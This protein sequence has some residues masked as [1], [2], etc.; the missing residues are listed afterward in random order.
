[1]SFSRQQSNQ[2]L[3]LD[4]VLTDTDCSDLIGFYQTVGPSHDYRST[5]VRP[6]RPGQGV[7]TYVAKIVRAFNEFSRFSIGISWCEIVEWPKNASHA[8]HVDKTDPVA[9]FT[10]ITYL[11]SDYTGG[12]TY[13]KN[14][15]SITPKTGRTIYFDGLYYVHGVTTVETGTRYTLPIWYSFYEK[16]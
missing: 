9:A 13:F 11:N 14:D 15:L 5:K 16:V 12:C 10:S 7:D 4:N 8:L 6:L 2:I 3:V 1:M